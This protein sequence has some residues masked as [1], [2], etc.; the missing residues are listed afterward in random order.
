VDSPIIIIIII[1]ILVVLKIIG[2]EV[3][4]DTGRLG[5]LSVARGFRSRQTSRM[6]EIS[7]SGSLVIGSQA[8]MM[9]ANS[10]SLF[11]SIGQSNSSFCI[12]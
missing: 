3:I 5:G 2:A 7:T 12:V 4:L 11:E 10:Q 9:G 8:R 1:I 6:S